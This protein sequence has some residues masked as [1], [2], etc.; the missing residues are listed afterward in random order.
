[1]SP[2]YTEIVNALQT[3]ID[4]QFYAVG[5]LLPSETQLTREFRTSRSTVV[6]ALRQLRRQ[7]WVRGVQG[8]GRIVLG[9]PAT[10]LSA[11]PHRIR[12]LLQADRHAALLE[13]R[14]VPAAPR[15]A[16]ALAV[17]RGAPLIARRYLLALPACPPL[18]LTTVYIPA[19]MAGPATLR[20]EAGLL[21]DLERRNT[22]AA[23]RVVERLGARLA[24]EPE[25]TALSLERPRSVA[26]SLLTVL[27]VADRPL[28]ALDAVLSREA[29]DLVASYELA[30]VA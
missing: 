4:H 5:A 18:G 26:V 24:T 17:P 10:T 13:A 19:A 14:R 6:R 12:F 3:R 27:D 2:K 23:H 16:A 1:M 29:P 22:V 25:A 20:P 7:G 15:I 11:L 28:L 21:V 30:T 8:K 9:R